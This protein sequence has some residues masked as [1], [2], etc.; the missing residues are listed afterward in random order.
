[1]HNAGVCWL[2]C[3]DERRF[4]VA[5]LIPLDCDFF[6]L[7]LLEI[8]DLIFPLPQIVADRYSVKV[9]PVAKKK[10]AA[11]KKTVDD[12]VLVRKPPSTSAISLADSIITKQRSKA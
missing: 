3:L 6:H 9:K 1:M 2:C 4:F 5:R 7:C 12:D 8:A 11:G 10:P